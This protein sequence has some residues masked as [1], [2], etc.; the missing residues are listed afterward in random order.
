MSVGPSS[1]VASSLKQNHRP[2]Q[3]FGY[4]M[5]MPTQAEFFATLKATE[6]IISP[7]PEATKRCEASELQKTRRS[8]SVAGGEAGTQGSLTCCPICTLPA[9]TMATTPCCHVFCP[10]CANTWFQTS[11]TCPLCRRELFSGA[12]APMPWPPA[13]VPR[14]IVWL[15]VGDSEAGNEVAREEIVGR[16]G[17]LLREFLD[18]EEPVRISHGK[19]FR[20]CEHWHLNVDEGNLMQFSE[21]LRLAVFVAVHWFKP[22]FRVHDGREVNASSSSL[23]QD[24]E[25]V[26][27][28]Q[29]TFARGACSTA[30]KGL[31]DSMLKTVN[32]FINPTNGELWQIEARKGNSLEQLR[33]KLKDNWDAA[34]KQLNAR[35]NPTDPLTHEWPWYSEGY[36][37]PGIPSRR[38]MQ[39]RAWDPV[40][41]TQFRGSLKFAD[42]VHDV[43]EY[44]VTTASEFFVHEEPHHST[45]EVSDLE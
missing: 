9:G 31:M 40:G 7:A 42:D 10:D 44:I 37:L 34:W 27:R 11:R 17:G 20:T 45:A 8:R 35:E 43:V 25:E 18:V 24:S 32:Q 16:N 33:V 21:T 19:F 4:T 14:D 23:M 38:D 30:W 15:H 22:R 36:D 13:W 29:R 41:F 3:A 39:N 1:S 5:A 26:W 12:M 28:Q 2:T 6:Q